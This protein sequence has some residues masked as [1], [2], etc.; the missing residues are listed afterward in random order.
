MTNDHLTG[1]TDP[2]IRT[3]GIFPMIQAQELVLRF[4]DDLQAALR[5]SLQN[6]P[7]WQYAASQM[8]RVGQFELAAQSLQIALQIQP[9]DANL[10]YALAESFDADKKYSAAAAI[11]ETLQ[12]GP[13]ATYQAGYLLARVLFH[14]G[15][16]NAA[17]TAFNQTFKRW[18]CQTT[19]ILDELAEQLGIEP[20]N[21]FDETHPLVATGI[22]SEYTIESTHENHADGIASSGEV[23][24]PSIDFSD[25]GGMEDIKEEIRMKVVYP[26]KHPELFNSFGKRLGGGILLYGPPGCGK[27]YLARA[28]AGEVSASFISVGISEVLSAY[29]GE[30]GRNLHNIFEQ[31]RR[32]SPCVLFFDEADALG[33]SRADMRDAWQRSLINQF[34]I[35][36]DGIESSND[37]VL[38]LAATNAPW[39]LDS[40]LCRP[41]R[42]ERMI[43]VP[44]PDQPARLKILEI[45]LKGR[46]HTE[47]DLPYL[48]SITAGYSAADL[49]FIIEQAIELKLSAILRSG[50]PS[51][52]TMTDLRSC[53]SRARNSTREWF[54]SAKNYA[55][56]ANQDGRYD[57][58]L[59]YC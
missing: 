29:V 10:L 18:P 6:V 32:Q 1:K 45:L 2:T 11:L 50:S 26:L 25:V 34:L 4:P 33:A 53:I 44:P 42:L 17:R 59:R 7:L 8:H 30:S 27:T 3:D 19:L 36:L 47:L 46:P 5:C 39:Y 37:G 9:G 16:F 38:V 54:A 23:K 51:G 22:T 35:E 40:A 48:S 58:V 56:Y 12:V 52:L 43:F 28:M 24:R 14:A 13:N 55:T 31:A 15:Q 49:N 20:T 57:D 21:D 41:G